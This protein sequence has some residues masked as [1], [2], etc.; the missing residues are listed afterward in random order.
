LYLEIHQ[1]EYD[2]TF[3]DNVLKEIDY[4]L[5]AHNFEL[6]SLQNQLS[7]WPDSAFRKDQKS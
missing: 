4:F 1:L 6:V 7:H 3:F 5:R 2:E